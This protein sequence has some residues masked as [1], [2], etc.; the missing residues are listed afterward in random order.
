MLGRKSPQDVLNGYRKR[1]PFFPVFIAILAVLLVIIGIVI[2]VLW[3]TGGGFSFNLFNKEPTPTS[4]MPPTPVLSPTPS[5]IPTETPTP[6]LTVSPTPSGPF[7]YEILEFDSCWGIAEK[8]E[9]D[10]QTLLAINNFE[11]GTCLIYP[12]LKIKV[13]APGQTLPTP[14]PVPPDTASGTR[15]DY[16]VQAGDSLKS[17]ADQ[18]NSTIE[19]IIAI[20]K[21]KID[22]ENNIPV[23][24][25][26][27]IRVNLVT[28]TPTFAP[29]STLAS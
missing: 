25:I 9:V 7:E 6:T 22:D 13:P 11:D 14:T 17:I 15:I 27:V 4:T 5:L 16:A 23:G 26:L 28:P 10:L 29:T 2:I 3:I 12:G 18:F 1:K 8:F 21:D 19:D 20:N 24:V